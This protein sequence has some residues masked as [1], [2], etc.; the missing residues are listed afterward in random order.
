MCWVHLLLFATVLAG[1]SSSLA[2]RCDGT[3]CTPGGWHW[4]QEFCEQKERGRCVSYSAS[5]PSVCSDTFADATEGDVLGYSYDT[6]RDKGYAATTCSE[7][8]YEGD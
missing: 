4:C 3:T 8:P 1:C 5:A 7:S 6:C 2:S